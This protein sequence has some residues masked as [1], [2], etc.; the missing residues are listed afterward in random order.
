VNAYVSYGSGFET[1]TFN[2]LGYRAD[3]GTGLAFDL[4]PARSRNAE[5]GLKL[6]PDPRIEANFA[7]FRADTRNELA[8]AT[9]AGGRTTYQN[10]GTAR[11]DGAEAALAWRLADDWKLQFAWTWLDA[12]FRSAFLTCAGTPCTTPD[13]PVAAGTRIPGIPQ[14]NLH[15]ALRWGGER[16]WHA[17][18]QGDY[19]DAVPVN[20]RGT[21]AAPSYIVVAAD[22][23]YAF[24]LSSGRVDAFARIDNAFDRHYAGSVIV[25]DTNGRYFEPAAGRSVMV[26]LKWR[27]GR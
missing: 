7:V 3:G 1:P 18:V 4:D 14:A 21:D 9:S 20:D 17:G 11:R 13:T 12:R 16:G 19:V 15:A 2:E 22:L 24:E 26:G 27:W 25:N 8:V 5:L 6:R 23:G 10:I